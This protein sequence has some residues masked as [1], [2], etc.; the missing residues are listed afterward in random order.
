ME[1]PTSFAVAFVDVNLKPWKGQRFWESRSWYPDSRSR[2]MASG[3]ENKNGQIKQHGVNNRTMNLWLKKMPSLKPTYITPENRPSQKEAI[4]FQALIFRGELL[5]SG[6][7]VPYKHYFECSFST[8]AFQL[9]GSTSYDLQSGPAVILLFLP[10]TGFTAQSFA[11]HYTIIHVHI[12]HTYIYMYIIY[13]YILYLYTSIYVYIQT[14][15]TKNQPYLE[16]GR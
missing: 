12:L 16:H 7:V 5:V 1:R 13:I 6:R 9:T 10:F 3:K 4:V 14:F 11:H 2:R 8:K 15:D